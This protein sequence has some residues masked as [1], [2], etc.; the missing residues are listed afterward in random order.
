MSILNILNTPLTKES[1]SVVN[2]NSGYRT[3]DLLALRVLIQ[4]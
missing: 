3:E 2:T 4:L 1:S